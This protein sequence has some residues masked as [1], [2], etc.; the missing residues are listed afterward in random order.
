MGNFLY[1]ALRT[2]LWLVMVV[3]VYFAI[4]H[5]DGQLWL[6]VPIVAVVVVIYSMLDQPLREMRGRQRTR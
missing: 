5:A 6:Q 3:A 2:F 1:W 4:L